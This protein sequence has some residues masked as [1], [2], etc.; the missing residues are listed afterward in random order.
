MGLL[1]KL[2]IPNA[3]ALEE[4]MKSQMS[5]T[6]SLKANPITGGLRMGQLAKAKGKLGSLDVPGETSVLL[7]PG[8]V[9][10][11]FTEGGDS[12]LRLQGT[13]FIQ[14]KFPDFEVALSGGGEPLPVSWFPPSE[15]AVKTGGVPPKNKALVGEVEIPATGEYVFRAPKPVPDL[16]LADSSKVKREGSLLI[17]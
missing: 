2:G 13:T 3:D 5:P 14:P 12:A 6:Q 10:L 15:I 8:K 9:R 16:E 11:T 17:D 7:Q 4:R 1:K